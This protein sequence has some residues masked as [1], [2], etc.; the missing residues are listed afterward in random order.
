MQSNFYWLLNS[1]F[2][3]VATAKG[4]RNWKKSYILKKLIFLLLTVPQTFHVNV[5]GVRVMPWI[6]LV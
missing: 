5:S 4:F 1:Y 2:I 6:S 3:Y